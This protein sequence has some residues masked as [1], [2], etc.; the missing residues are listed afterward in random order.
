MHICIIVGATG[1][2][3]STT[4]NTLLKRNSFTIGNHSQ[5]IT[6]EI[7]L[8]K[9]DNDEM[10]LIDCPGFCDPLQ[11]DVFHKEFLRLRRRIK[12]CVAILPI[13]AFIFVIK[14]DE[15]RSN[16]FL[17]AAKEFFKLF[18]SHGIKSAILVCIQGN[19]RRIYN[20]IEFTQI[21]KD[22]DGYKFMIKQ[23]K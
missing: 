14:F 1:Q 9:T 3:K 5:R 19:E 16:S 23:I 17:P 21:L 4:G 12:A 11:P 6:T 10:M 18:G 8:D 7:Q 20:Q 22:S 13:S 15:G 2:G